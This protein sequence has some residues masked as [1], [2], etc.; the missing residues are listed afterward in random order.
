MAIINS[1]PENIASALIFNETDLLPALIKINQTGDTGY[2]TIEIR[3]DHYIIG[4]ENSRDEP[5]LTDITIYPLVTFYI[6]INVRRDVD[7]EDPNI[8]YQTLQPGHVYR[9]YLRYYTPGTAFPEYATS[10]TL[11]FYKDGNELMTSSYP[12]LAMFQWSLTSFT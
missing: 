2:D 3:Q 1:I 5:Y 7:L 6:M 11:Y 12:S 10:G 8:K 4:G 9:F